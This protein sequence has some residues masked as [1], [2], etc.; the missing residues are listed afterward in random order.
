MLEADV[1]G[2][3][4][5]LG[6]VLLALSGAELQNGDFAA[7]ERHARYAL[8]STE[9]AAPD[10]NYEQIAAEAMLTHALWEQRKPEATDVAR[11]ALGHLD[12]VPGEYPGRQRLW[13]DLR[14]FLTPK[15][16]DDTYT[17]AVQ[18]R[19]AA[20]YEVADKEMGKGR[21]D[22]AMP[23]IEE[24]LPLAR[25]LGHGSVVIRFLHL[26]AQSAI[27]RGDSTSAEH[28]IDES[29]GIARAMKDETAVA[30][31]EDARKLVGT[32]PEK[33]DLA[34]RIRE[35]DVALREERWE[36]AAEA[37]N[38]AIDLSARLGE[39]RSEAESRMK[40]F[41][42]YV[43]LGR[44]EEATAQFLEADR[45]AIQLGMRGGRELYEK[46]FAARPY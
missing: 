31:L 32:A 30:T 16:P 1:A 5:V 37:L 27:R 42:A 20:L 6:G 35:G 46:L 4:V 23:H 9:G 22:A 10:E 40:M 7:A 12:D 38:Q 21:W 3:P 29:L 24:A 14:L 41:A 45:L 43:A 11:A 36:R 26:A 2:A 33:F 18:H 28:F 44:S 19:I 17:T 13:S 15:G 8:K 25:R 34:D 39:R